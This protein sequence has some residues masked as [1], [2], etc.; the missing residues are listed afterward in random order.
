M[1]NLSSLITY[2]KYSVLIFSALELKMFSLSGPSCQRLEGVGFSVSTSRHIHVTRNRRS[3]EL[4]TDKASAR[5]RRARPHAVSGAHR[6]GQQSGDR[7]LT[8]Q[9]E[10]PRTTLHA[11]VVDSSL[12]I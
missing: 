8:F 5:S 3:K 6:K 2:M 11:V 4:I 12:L 10:D 7:I 1:H 9:L